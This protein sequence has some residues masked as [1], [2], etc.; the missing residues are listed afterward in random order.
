MQSEKANTRVKQVKRQLEEAEEEM[1][2]HT[3]NKR[4]VQRD[5]DE[6][7]EAYE[8]AKREV[9]QLRSKLRAGGS[10]TSRIG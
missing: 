6:M 7:T 2:R 4:K 9:E 10:A 3:A 5:L 8:A 1:S